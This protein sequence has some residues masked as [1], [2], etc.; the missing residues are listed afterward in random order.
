MIVP[1]SLAMFLA[2]S[3]PSFRSFRPVVNSNARSGPALALPRIT[4]FATI[5]EEDELLPKKKLWLS[6]KRSGDEGY[7]NDDDDD[8]ATGDDI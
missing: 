6:E 8:D 3:R 5:E 2:V 1:S 4:T 7:P